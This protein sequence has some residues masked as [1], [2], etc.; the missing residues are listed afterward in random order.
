M[1]RPSRLPATVV[2]VYDVSFNIRVPGIGVGKATSHDIK[3]NEVSAGKMPDKLKY[4]AVKSSWIKAPGSDATQPRNGVHKVDDP[5]GILYLTDIDSVLALFRSHIEH[6]SIQIG[7]TRTDA[8]YERIF[9]G[10][11]RISADEDAQGRT[12]HDRVH[13]QSHGRSSAQVSCRRRRSE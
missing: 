10:V 5:G 8:K 7:A 1:Y 2:P 11:I 9:A 12:M 3:W 6:K 13:R 4:A